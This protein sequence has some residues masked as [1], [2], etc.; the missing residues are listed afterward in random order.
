[1]ADHVRAQQKLDHAKVQ[2]SVSH[3][4]IASLLLRRPLQLSSAVKTASIDAHGLITIN[5]GYVNRLHEERVIFLLAHECL[6]Y[7]LAH[8]LRCGDRDPHLWNIACDAVINETL[9]EAGIGTYITGGVRFRG[10]QRLTSERVYQILTDGAAGGRR[11]VL[12]GI[13]NDLDHSRTPVDA[14]A[15]QGAIANANRDLHEAFRA[16]QVAGGLPD[17]LVRRIERHLGA[18]LPW[19]EVLA[20]YLTAMAKDDYR[21]SRPNR[22][23]LTHGL[24][25]P[26]Q[27]ERP[28]LGTVVIAVDTSCSI[29]DRDL[30][31]YLWHV[32]CIF[33]AVRP[34]QVTVFYCDDRIRGSDTFTQPPI[35]WTHVEGGGGTCFTPVFEEIAAQGIIPDVLLYFTDLAGVFPD[36]APEFPTI[37]ITRGMGKAPF[38]KTLHDQQAPR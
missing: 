25:L 27:G 8:V 31:H 26:G 30:A 13:G 10:A 29:T 3:P 5:P 24:I 16:G 34:E 15:R 22:R 38:G 11:L 33:E 32:E 20:D 4:F 14:A 23:Y 17:G 7:A 37:W 19:H 18:Q 2:L 9:I 21:W 1:M 28:G 6:H 36:R 35:S 12:E